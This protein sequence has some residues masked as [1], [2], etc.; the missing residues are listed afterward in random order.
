MLPFILIRSASTP[1]SLLAIKLNRK[2]AFFISS[3]VPLLVVHST[4]VTKKKRSA[5]GE[6]LSSPAS[7]LS[8]L[9]LTGSSSPLIAG[10]DQRINNRTGNQQGI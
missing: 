2:H 5:V 3:E 8:A 7:W 9:P 1:V 6:G 4:L 10:P